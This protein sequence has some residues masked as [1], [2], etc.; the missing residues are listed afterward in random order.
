MIM[1]RGPNRASF[2]W[3]SSTHNTRIERLWVE[4][5][6]QFAR[7]W[8]AFFTRLGDLH[9]LDRKNPHHIWLLH[10]LFLGDVNDDCRAFRA[11]W[12]AHP[13]SGRGASDQ[14]PADLRFM[15]QLNN[16]VYADPVD[17]L[18]PETIERY[19]GVEGPVRIRRPGHTGAGHP[20]D[21]DESEEYL[22][23][24]VAEDLAHNIR[25]PPVKVAR[26]SNPF[27]SAEIEAGFF[28]ALAEIVRCGILPNGYGVVQD[29]WEDATY[30]VMEAI[31]P[32]T[33]GREI[34]VELPRD[35]WLPRAILFAQ[36]L[37]TMHRSLA[38]Q[39]I[40]VGDNVAPGYESS[41]SSQDDI[42]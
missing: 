21:E 4:V 27:H 9:R 13:V 23:N 10:R 22:N 17:K 2:M 6:V 41:G 36:G 33:R 40:R 35:I 8:R 24:A 37:D 34:I 39:P 20:E 42:D 1:H 14:S 3:G 18:H 15:G 25:H 7:R 29:E 26:H 11:Q 30:P 32:G 28:G 12:N 38:F 19:Y 5:G 16:G 31:N